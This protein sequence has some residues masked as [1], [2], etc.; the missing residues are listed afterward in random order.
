MQA[1]CWSL[2]S[3]GMISGKD[4][5]FLELFTATRWLDILLCTSGTCWTSPT[6]LTDH[7]WASRT[8]KTVTRHWK[9]EQLTRTPLVLP[10]DHSSARY[11]SPALTTV[12]YLLCRLFH[13]RVCDLHNVVFK[14]SSLST[15]LSGS[16]LLISLDLW[17]DVSDVP[18]SLFRANIRLQCEPCAY[19]PSY[20]CQQLRRNYIKYNYTLLHQPVLYLPIHAITGGQFTTLQAWINSWYHPLLLGCATLTSLSIIHFCLADYKFTQ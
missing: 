1:L 16:N 5:P 2:A 14:H 6:S 3:N 13:S 19:R 18:I 9:T 11:S 15:V 7:V 8:K 20:G 17:R 12:L 4:R 10:T